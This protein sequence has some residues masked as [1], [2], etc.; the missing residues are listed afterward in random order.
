M[1]YLNNLHLPLGNNVSVSNYSSLSR[2][3]PNFLSLTVDN[4]A[5]NQMQLTGGWSSSLPLTVLGVIAMLIFWRRVEAKST[6]LAYFL[7]ALVDSF[8]MLLVFVPRAFGLI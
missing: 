8:S 2:S 6:F 7:F 3:W 5:E 4:R 1:G